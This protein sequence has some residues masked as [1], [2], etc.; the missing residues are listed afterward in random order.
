[1]KLSSMCWCGRSEVEI[2]I[3]WVSSGQT[4]SCQ[5]TGCGPGCQYTALEADSFDDPYDEPI[6]I[7]SEQRTYKMAKFNPAD[8]RPSDDSTP[9]LPAR[10]NAVSI[11]VGEGLCGCGCGEAPA[12]RGTKFLMGHDA[13]LKGV[14][15]RAHASQVRIALFENSTGVA[16]VVD[17][18]E[19][20]A[21][22]TSTKTDWTELVQAGAD[23]IAARRGNVDRRFAERQVLD[24]A[25][26]DG[27]V[28]VGRWE[29]T[30][31][32]AAIYHDPVTNKYTVEYVNSVGRIEQVEVDVA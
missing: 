32:V 19:Y 20:A 31:S 23:K 17:P 2:P 18:L 6:V 11:L 1:M 15:T 16:D 24:R 13:R 7:A 22:F 29:A 3:D 12:G 4:A 9:G 30:D 26:R 8:Y 5:Y 25:T 28:R 21:R 10:D 27:A 14:L